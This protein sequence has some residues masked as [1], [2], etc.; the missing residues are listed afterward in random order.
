MKRPGSCL[1]RELL[2]LFLPVVAPVILLSCT[3]VPSTTSGSIPGTPSSSPTGTHTSSSTPVPSTS[4][5]STSSPLPTPTVPAIP[6]IPAITPPPSLIGS[7]ATLGSTEYVVFAWNDLGMHCANP[8]YD[9]AVLLPPYNNLWVQVIRRGNPPRVVTSG[10]TVEYNIINN[11]YSYGK[12]SFGQFWDNA[13]KIFGIDLA[14]NTGL[15]LTDPTIHNGLSG[16]MA[17]KA[18]HFEA[19]GIPLTPINDDGSWNPYQIGQ[20]TVKDASGNIVARTDVTVPIS[21]EINCSKCHGADPFQNVLVKHDAHNGTNLVSQA[22]VLCAGCHGD[23]A[24]GSPRTTGMK[25]LSEAVHG[26]HATVS[27]QPAC[28]D[29]HPGQ[30]TRCSRSLAHTA[31]DGN[32]QT[33]HGDL[34]QISGSIESGRTPWVS[35]PKCVTCHTGVAEVDTGTTLYRNDIGHGGV[36][37]ASCHSSPHAMIPTN[38]LS[39]NYQALQYEGAAKTVGSCG[40]CHPTSRGGGE[41]GDYQE[42]HGGANPRVPNACNICHTSV[43]TNTAQWPHAFQW[44]ATQGTGRAGEGDD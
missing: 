41:I 1:I 38:V 27:P 19:I 6:A 28:Y 24:L 11:T 33:C 43:T 3:A 17:A 30:V 2:V 25:Y 31:A 36:Y 44:K 21:D 16:T 22:P 5:T 13:S 10:L 32:C 14:R 18:D 9:K 29:C 39:D 23:P 35:E 4:Q 42:E 26:F 7:R 15:N 40:A 20:I 34:A 8:T 37:C 12:Q